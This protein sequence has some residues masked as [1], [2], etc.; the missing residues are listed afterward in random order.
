[1]VKNGEAG[2][3]RRIQEKAAIIEK[4]CFYGRGKQGG[5]T[6][7]YKTLK[8]SLSILIFAWCAFCPQAGAVE[9][10]DHGGGVDA[11]PRALMSKEKAAVEEI[12]MVTKTLSGEIG[13]VGPSGIALV[14]EKDEA[15]GTEKEMFLPFEDDVK[16]TRYNSR[17]D[18]GAGDKVTLTYDEH[19]DG[20]RR[21][22]KA[23]TLLRK[24]PKEPLP[25]EEEEVDEQNE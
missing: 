13:A 24:A 9:T 23:V 15:Q 25:S 19:E 22:L 8:N 12:K 1:M 17:K 21:L 18:M 11:K 16:L 2:W 6:V 3:L 10:A 20:S 14:Y 5:R 7:V 4:R